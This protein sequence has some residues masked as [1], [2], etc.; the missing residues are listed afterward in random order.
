MEGDKEMIEHF[1]KIINT[2]TVVVIFLFIGVTVGIYLGYGF[3][4]GKPTWK[5]VVF[6]LIYII[7]FFIALKRIRKIWKI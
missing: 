4:E 1:R 2:V 6:Y 7:L 5:N 3:F